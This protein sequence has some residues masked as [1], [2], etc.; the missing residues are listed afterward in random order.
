[1]PKPEPKEK[2]VFE[3]PDQPQVR[4][5]NPTDRVNPDLHKT[6]KV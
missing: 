3:K 4:H 1:M 2:P 5:Q 6:K